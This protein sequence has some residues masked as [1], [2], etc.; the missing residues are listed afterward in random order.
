[1][2]GRTARRIMTR[3]RAI[4]WRPFSPP[5]AGSPGENALS[6]ST[7]PHIIV[8]SV[9]RAKSNAPTSPPSFRLYC[10]CCRAMS[11]RR[12][13]R[14]RV[15]CAF[16]SGGRKFFGATK[17]AVAFQVLRQM[18]R[19]RRGKRGRTDDRASL[20]AGSRPIRPPRVGG[21][22]ETLFPHPPRIFRPGTTSLHLI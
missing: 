3:P 12:T 5:R 2:D 14:R 18:R 10:P 11:A 9:S 6:A 17:T 4:A 7:R 16:A 15:S 8:Y 13:A 22:S 20:L 21:T 19:L 1:M